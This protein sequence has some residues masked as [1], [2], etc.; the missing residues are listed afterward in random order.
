MKKNKVNE[1][2]QSLLAQS[3]ALPLPQ[4]VLFQGEWPGRLRD[5]Y[6]AQV[7]G[8]VVGA[9]L[10]TVQ[11]FFFGGGGEGIVFYSFKAL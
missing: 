8:Q 4:G 10:C 3:L 6:Q 11:E 2:K 7:R 5:W 1:Y 9:A